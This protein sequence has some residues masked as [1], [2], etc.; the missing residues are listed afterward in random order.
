MMADL[1][2]FYE[3]IIP[4]QSIIT[5]ANIIVHVDLIIGQM[6]HWNI[7]SHLYSFL[8]CLNV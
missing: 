6:G 3:L 8:S 5:P 7:R 2:V 1:K 4:I